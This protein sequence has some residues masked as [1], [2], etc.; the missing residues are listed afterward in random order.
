MSNAQPDAGCDW[1]PF[2]DMRGDVDA[3]RRRFAEIASAESKDE[4]TR[5]FSSRAIRLFE[6]LGLALRDLNYAHRLMGESPSEGRPDRDDVSG[7]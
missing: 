4:P 5:H 6:E 2:S 1:T 7:D 3:L